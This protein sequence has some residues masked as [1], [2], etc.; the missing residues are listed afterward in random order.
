[1]GKRFIRKS[2]YLR[3]AGPIGGRLRAATIGRITGGRILEAV[4]VAADAVQLSGSG[5]RFGAFRAGRSGGRL[6]A[7]G[8]IAAAARGGG[9]GGRRRRLR[10]AVAR[11]Q[12]MVFDLREHANHVDHRCVLAGLPDPLSR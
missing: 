10:F 3:N 7:A 4:D 1:M 2:A 11:D 12:S 8:R 6:F 9:R 5:R